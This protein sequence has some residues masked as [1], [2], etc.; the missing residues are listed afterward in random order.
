MNKA[1]TRFGANIA[2]SIVT[3]WGSKLIGMINMIVL[4][5]ILTPDDFGIV[6]M[7]TIVMMLLDSMTQV[8]VHLY[9]LRQKGDNPRI[10]NTGWTV[11]LIQAL[12]IAIV[13][14]SI[15]PLVAEFF[16]EKAL[17]NI[18]YCLA[19]IKLILGLQN[20]GIYIAQKQLDFKLDFTLSTSSRLTYMIA[21][22]GF[23]LWLENYW[24]I[25][26][27]QACAAIISV[28]LSYK[29]HEFRPKFQLY[30]WRKLLSFSSAT[31]PLSIGRFVS[32]QSDVTIVGK[33]GSTEL[34]G[35]YNIAS[36][37]ASLFTKELMMPVIKGIIPNLSK[38]KGSPELPV[39]LRMIITLALYAF[40]PLG[41]GLSLVSPELVTVILG[42]KWLAVTPILA[43]L[44]IY[45]ML[46]GLSMF[47]SE[48][49]LI[50]FELEKLSN[51]LMWFRNAILLSCIASAI[52]LYSIQD[53]PK[54]MVIAACLSFPF[55]LFF[56]SRSM[57]IAIRFLVAYWW[58]A[59][60]AV[61]GMVAIVNLIPYSHLPVFVALLL[62]SIVGALAYLLIIGVCYVLR[63]KPENTP[64]SL[65]LKRILPKLSNLRHRSS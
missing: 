19:V 33:L 1:H 45:A 29:L 36:S 65:I 6:A 12:V 35:Q 37:L 25:I 34:L 11:Q 47:M 59:I 14:F 5:R 56:V 53:I 30:Q 10:F 60:I 52:T 8:G 39:T 17:T 21:A 57:N 32:N 54:A 43:W 20:F 42:D 24:A 64:E 46:S 49:F 26:W 18:I 38:L 3:R 48:Q 58:P 31:I 7:A 55:T 51:R 62:K 27:G 41:V 2:W 15:A 4:A 23:A 63:G 16:G 61:I 44:S 22:I 28:F 13:L 40:L 9:V 50:V